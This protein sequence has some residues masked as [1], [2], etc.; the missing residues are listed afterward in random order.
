M[1]KYSLFVLAGLIFL[2]IA[3][4]KKD[5]PIIPPDDQPKP[6]RRDYTW[7]VDTL[8]GDPGDL[9]YM[10]SLWGSSPTD[11]WA[12]GH[13]QG[14]DL[15][16]WHYDGTSWQKDPSR[17]SSN[18]MS[19]YGFAQN[20]VWASDA[21]GRG[22]Y[23]YDGQQWSVVYDYNNPGTYLLATNIWGDSPN[24]IFVAGAIDTVA[25]GNYKGVVLHFD[26]VTWSFLSITPYRIGFTW[27]RRGIKES[28]RYY[29]SAVRY[30]SV[31]DTNKIFELD[32]TTLK[33]IYT[34]QQST[35]VNEMAGRIYHCIGQKIFKCQ[36]GQLVV[37]KDFSG[38]MHGGRMWGRNEMDFI[39]EGYT[40]VMHYNGTDIQL[41]YPTSMSIYDIAVYSN[42]VFILCYTGS[43]SVIVHGTLK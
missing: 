17:L 13:A 14:S 8:K 40:G 9:F 26:G 15:S 38:T 6:G 33:E 11:I 18:L 28:N 22:V 20:D 25:N 10:F 19:V 30:E 12:V 1:K 43:N 23:H 31:G 42:D 24:N 7:T 4:C 39:T 16:M 37:W 35:S 29:L 32:G 5:N 36:N 21:P 2:I 41:L 3:C 34:G 27:I